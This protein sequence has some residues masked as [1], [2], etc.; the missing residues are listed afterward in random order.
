M[1]VFIISCFIYDINQKTNGASSLI[2]AIITV[3]TP[4]QAI[5]VSTSDAGANDTLSILAAAD[6]SILT[7]R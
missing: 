1:I 5:R 3:G 7:G 6:G 2:S 4:P